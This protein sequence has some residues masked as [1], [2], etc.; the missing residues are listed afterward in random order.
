MQQSKPLPNK[1]TLRRPVGHEHVPQLSPAAVVLQQS[2]QGGRGAGGAAQITQLGPTLTVLPDDAH[3]P[4]SGGGT[5]LL[6]RWRRE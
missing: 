6:A 1:L 2:D 4:A 5:T 3:Q